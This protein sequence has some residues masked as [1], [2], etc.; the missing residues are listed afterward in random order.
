[1]FPKANSIVGNFP[2]EL[3]GGIKM[4][5]KR[6]CKLGFGE[7][8]HIYAEHDITNTMLL[9]LMV[10]YQWNRLEIFKEQTCS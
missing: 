1:M 10:P 9:G 7:Y 2:K 8:V 5:Y 3:F 6:D 4:D